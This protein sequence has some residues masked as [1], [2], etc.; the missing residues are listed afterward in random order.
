[1]ILGPEQMMKLQEIKGEAKYFI[2]KF[3]MLYLIILLSSCV[4]IPLSKEYKELNPYMKGTALIFKS[5][6]KTI[7]DTIFIKIIRNGYIDG[8]TIIFKN[9]QIMNVYAYI[10]HY[11]DDN[12][13]LFETSVFGSK[14]NG[15]IRFTIKLNENAKFF[16]DYESINFLK[17]SKL[18]SLTIDDNL[19]TDVVILYS[20]SS[21]LL[22]RNNELSKAYW[23]LSHGYIRLEK[24]DGE[25]YDL[26]EQYI[27]TAYSH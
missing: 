15:G 10:P 13:A 17:N 18:D 1:M 25:M 19:Y 16:A 6:K 5:N 9:P 20:T 14:M 3:K 4:K 7:N 8:P 23:S 26:V 27:D 21:Y 22:Y 24:P 2:M 11:Y 12:S